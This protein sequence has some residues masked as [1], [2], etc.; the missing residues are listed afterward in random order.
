MSFSFNHYISE[1][2]LKS[3]RHKSLIQNF[4]YLSFLQ[5][6]NI[7]L[8]II[9]Y[10]YLIRVLGKEVY[11][12]IVFVQAIISYLS[13][14][15]SFGF[16]YTATKSISIHRSDPAKI[17]EIVSSI[18][19]IKSILFI[20]SLILLSFLLILIP[21]ANNHKLLLFLSMWTC[22]YDVIFPTWFFQG[23]E[24]MKYITVLNLTS[25]LIF[26][27][28]IFLIIKSSDDYLF[29]PVI[30]GIGALISGILSLHIL[31]KKYHIRI[32]LQSFSCLRK[33][34]A[35]AFPVFLS[36]ISIKLYLTTNK[37][38][39]GIFFGM[40]EV[41]YFDLAEKITSLIK[42]PLQII[43]QI[44]YPKIAKEKN[45]IFLRQIFYRTIILTIIIVIVSAFLNQIIIKLLGGNQ[46][47]PS[48]P[49]VLI[50]LISLIP[51]TI[52]LFFANIS[53]LAWN[54]NKDYLKLRVSTFIIYIV[55]LL[56][57]TTLKLI[58]MKTLAFTILGLEIVTAILAIYICE[59]R[60]ISLLQLTPKYL[61]FNA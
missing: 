16:D 26:L 35:D 30:N 34:L 8:P 60:K 39:I 59:K 18:Y 29:V 27:V 33:Y 32:Q 55:S 2:K 5:F 46:M 22:L 15:V 19:I 54:Y 52:S 43:G 38:I 41:S 28:L 10:P 20:I 50:L 47:L 44:I 56:F 61:V 40:R 14:L 17:N 4:S 12:L 11:G 58:N 1:F 25:R 3:I 6:F 9:T 42:T 23:I 53:L 48:S 37:V 13:I 51:I 45:I 49:I 21:N 7:A 36:S 24:R 31:Y 57:L